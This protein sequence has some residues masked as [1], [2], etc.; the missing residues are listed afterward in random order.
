MPANLPDDGPV[1]SEVLGVNRTFTTGSWPRKLLRLFAHPTRIASF[2]RRK[3]GYKQA[4]DHLGSDQTSA[5]AMVDSSADE[6]EFTRRGM[7]VADLLRPALLVRPTDVVMEVGCGPARIGRELAPHC[8]TWIGADISAQMIRRARARTSHLSNVQFLVLAGARLDG[9]A[10]GSIDRLYCHSVLAHIDKEDLYKYL[11]EF[12]RVLTRGGLAYIDTW[13]LPHPD[14]WKWFLASANESPLSGRKV[15][16]KP[17]FCTAL[18]FRHFIEQAGLTLVALD[19]TS[20]LL[21]AFVTPQAGDG[22]S[23]AQV[24]RFRQQIAPL[25]PT[26]APVTISRSLPSMKPVA[27]AAQPE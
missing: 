23:D 4:W 14:A 10:D 25:L 11:L 9:T 8:R 12:R 26:S 2:V 20:H 27:D 16:W 13:N 5:Y 3:Q 7:A 22:E 24:A 17:Q 1:A 21:Q 18:E 6:A 15:S 19:D